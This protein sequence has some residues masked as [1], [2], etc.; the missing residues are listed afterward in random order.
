MIYPLVQDLAAEKFPVA[1]TCRVLG[2]SKQAFYQWKA[3]PVS[4]RGYDDDTWSM[5]RSTSTT[6]PSSATGSSP[7]LTAQGFTASRKRVGRLVV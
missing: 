4:D 3:K 6:T 5:P 2:F 1:V 7:T